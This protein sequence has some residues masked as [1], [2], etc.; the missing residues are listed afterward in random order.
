[1][2]SLDDTK[3]LAKQGEYV[4]KEDLTV[5]ANIIPAP[6]LLKAS[7]TH[8]HTKVETF[9]TVPLPLYEVPEDIKQKVMETDTYPDFYPWKSKEH[10]VTR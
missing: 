5:P 2:S 4:E 3:F 1:M 8:I 10:W 7:K 9:Y 6:A